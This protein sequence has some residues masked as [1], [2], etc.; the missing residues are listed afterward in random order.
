METEGVEKKLDMLT[1]MIQTMGE[2]INGKLNT[3]KEE[4]REVHKQ[5][6]ELRKDTEQIKI[7]MKELIRA[8]GEARNRNIVIFGWR[9]E[10]NENKFETH[11]RVKD[12][13]SKVL[14]INSK[15]IKIDN[16]DWIGKHKQ[17][18]PLLIKFTDSLTKEF[19]MER[20]SLFKGYKLRLEDDHN[21]E[22]R[23]IR[24][25]LVEYMWEARR[26]GQHA[27]LIRDRIQ[28]SG[29]LYDLQTCRKNFKT[30]AEIDKERERESAR[31]TEE[32]KDE[33][34]NI[35]MIKV[36]LNEEKNNGEIK[37]GNKIELENLKR[38][39]EEETEISLEN[40]RKI[41]EGI[42]AISERLSEL[43][44]EDMEEDKREENT[45]TTNRKQTVSLEENASRKF[46]SKERKITSN[47]G[48]W[49]LRNQPDTGN[50]EIRTSKTGA[51]SHQNKENTSHTV[52]QEPDGE[53]LS[54]QI[55]EC[56]RTNVTERMRSEREGIKEVRNRYAYDLR[57]RPIT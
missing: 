51:R 39:E 27:V 33:V 5:I 26:R 4:W 15:N 17:F 53:Q 44:N 30:R 42:K 19:I 14:Q 50:H 20:K 40:G 6:Q 28:I 31:S 47:C 37:T 36:N 29:R 35:R 34:E 3:F 9:R 46:R 10:E 12:L 55:G 21:E 48:N 43:R 54:L 13:F 1:G 56:P 18:R 11:Q 16:I 32:G 41:L 57:N 23:S 49:I 38:K 45:E 52:S 8:E 22:V 2:E 25:I 7:Q 24:R